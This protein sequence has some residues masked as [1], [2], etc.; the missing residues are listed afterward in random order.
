MVFAGRYQEGGGVPAPYID[1]FIHLPRLDLEGIVIFLI[2]TGADRTSLHPRDV[3]YLRINYEALD[4]ATLTHSSGIGGQLGYHAEQAV[5]R[6]KDESGF[7]QPL[8]A[9]ILICQEG[10]DDQVAPLPSVLC[11][12]FL[13]LFDVR[14]DYRNDRVTLDPS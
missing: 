5:I 13:N 12:D 2:D 11:G 6:F 7:W 9:E 10:L 1:A 4:S 3:T 14:L 8:R